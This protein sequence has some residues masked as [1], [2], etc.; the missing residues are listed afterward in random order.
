[1]RT[2]QLGLRMGLTKQRVGALERAER[3]GKLT[4]NSLR[5][6]ADA[7]ECDLVYALVPRGGLEALVDRQARAMAAA[8]VRHASHSMSLEL[9]SIGV[10]ELDS[11]AQE[12]ADRLKS[13]LPSNLW[14]LTAHES[15]S[16]G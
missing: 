11:Q 14:N 3:E 8:I 16:A 2:S 9:Q 1:M 7:L 5:R 6:A 13:E 12:L 4:I 10:Q 15:G